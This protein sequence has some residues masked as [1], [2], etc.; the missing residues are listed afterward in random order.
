[1]APILNRE[2]SPGL[3]FILLVV[4]LAGS[5]LVVLDR[6]PVN[7]GSANLGDLLAL[8]SAV[9]AGAALSVLRE[10][11]KHDSS[12]VILF[13]MFAIGSVATG[14]FALV[15]YVPASGEAWL[16]ALAGSVC[17]LAA[18]ILLTVGYRHVPASEGALISAT[19][20]LVAAALGY[21]IFG[22]LVTVR[23][24]A[25]GVLI[26]AS[27]AAIALHSRRERRLAQNAQVGTPG[28]A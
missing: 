16:W 25:G 4:T 17:A 27:L 7:L 21:L 26:I 6:G 9:V 19:R 10:V 3:Y 1:M 2:R 13:Y 23:T 20:I 18:Q 28:G 14:L 12:V 15:G 5:A 24:L 11:R 22:D 8:F